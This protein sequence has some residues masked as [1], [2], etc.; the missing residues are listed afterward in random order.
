MAI[1]SLMKKRMRDELGNGFEVDLPSFWARALSFSME[2]NV[3][4]MKVMASLA[5]EGLNRVSFIS[6]HS[7]GEVFAA[8]YVSTYT[9]NTHLNSNPVINFTGC[10]N[11]R[12]S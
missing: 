8:E 2:E 9:K 3:L 11:C 10:R 5:R 6:L 7:N 12:I 1:M 4:T